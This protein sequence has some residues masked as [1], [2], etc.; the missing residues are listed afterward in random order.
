M[1]N[2]RGKKQL[3]EKSAARLQN[4]LSKRFGRI[5]SASE[6]QE[7][8]NSLMEFAYALVDLIPENE[9]AEEK[10]ISCR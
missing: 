9:S 5:L 2:V 10:K 8:Y 7:A 3:S 1:R 6:L 4:I